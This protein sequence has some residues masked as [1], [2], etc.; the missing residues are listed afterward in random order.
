MRSS[1][2]ALIIL[3]AIAVLARICFLFFPV[4]KG[5]GGSYV[6]LA[7]KILETGEYAS[8]GPFVSLYRP[9]VYPYFLVAL[10]WLTNGS[11]FAVTVV[12]H[13]LGI[14]TVL[15]IYFCAKRLWPH[16]KT[17]LWAALLSGTSFTFAYHECYILPESLF[18]FFVALHLYVVVILFQERDSPAYL[19]ILAGLLFGLTTLCRLEYVFFL[20]I[21]CF[22]LMMGSRRSWRRQISRVGLYAACCICI[23]G[24]WILRNG[25]EYDYYGLSPNGPLTFFDGPAGRCVNYELPTYAELKRALAQHIIYEGGMLEGD[26]F[27]FQCEEKYGID[28]A[29]MGKLITRLNMEVIR[30]NFGCYIRESMKMVKKLFFGDTWPPTVEWT[31]TR[32]PLFGSPQSGWQTGRLPQWFFSLFYNLSKYNYWLSMYLLPWLAVAGIFL[33]FFAMPS[34][35][36]E[37]GPAGRLLPL[38]MLSAYAGLLAIHTFGNIPGERSRVLI[39][40]GMIMFGAL[41]IDRITGLLARVRSRKNVNPG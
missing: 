13:L 22:V 28:Y 9:P 5:E 1:T 11:L 10:F 15:I 41:A 3:I 19:W 16:G 23:V 25:I 39:E 20:V 14:L 27:F 18:I 37:N 8:A 32:A 17:A 12:Q 30:T 7:S 38:M 4:S 29:H 33:A 21:S 40:P 34:G 36:V 35:M 2:K 6:Y 31:E 24:A 26:Q